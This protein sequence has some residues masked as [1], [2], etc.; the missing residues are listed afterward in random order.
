MIASTIRQSIRPCKQLKFETV[1]VLDFERFVIQMDIVY[2]NINL[3]QS[4]MSAISLGCL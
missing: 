4:A 1:K 2:R 3:Q